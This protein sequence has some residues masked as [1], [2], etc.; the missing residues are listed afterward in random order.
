MNIASGDRCCTSPSIFVAHPP[1][2]LEHERDLGHVLA[3]IADRLARVEALHPSQSLV[4]ATD[5]VGGAEQDPAPLSGRRPRP[6]RAVVER[7]PG[8]I[9]RRPDVGGLRVRRG[10]GHRAGS[11]VEHVEALAVTRVDPG[12]VDVVLQRVGHGFLP[13]VS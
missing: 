13:V 4:L 1:E 6:P 11:R 12:P 10:G 8:G 9:D 3:R 2:V 5:D 7:P